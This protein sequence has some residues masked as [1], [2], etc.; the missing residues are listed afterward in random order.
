MEIYK[1]NIFDSNEYD[2]EHKLSFT[3][4]VSFETL[5]NAE[6]SF[7][8]HPMTPN[9]KKS[10]KTHLILKR[11][12]INKEIMSDIDSTGNTSEKKLNRIFNIRV[13]N[14][15]INN[16]YKDIK[17]SNKN[18]NVQN[19]ET[20]QNFQIRR[21]IY[22]SEIKK[23]GKHHISFADNAL[24]IKKRME[25]EENNNQMKSEEIYNKF[26]SEKKIR[27][28]CLKQN[29]IDLKNLKKLKKGRIDNTNKTKCGL[30]EVVEI[31]NY[32]ELNKTDYF[33]NPDDE[34]KKEQQQEAVCCSSI[35]IIY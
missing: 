4:T 28:I 11:S 9:N 22:G 18:L 34:E 20:T 15:N 31:Q 6:K 35:C 19:V 13:K 7:R 12:P 17:E 3:N 30:V 14:K 5:T 1:K 29:I 26:N 8:R 33:Y 10:Y 2:E 32:K 25:L 27:R 21:D 23:G 16:R 24:L